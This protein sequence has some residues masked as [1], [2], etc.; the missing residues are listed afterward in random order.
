MVGGE[1]LAILEDSPL[2]KQETEVKT[3]QFFRMYYPL[4]IQCLV[5]N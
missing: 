1:K 2:K 3:T 5:E 4:Y